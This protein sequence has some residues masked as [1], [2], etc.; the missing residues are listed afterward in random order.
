MLTAAQTFDDKRGKIV[1]LVA[2]LTDERGSKM[3]AYRALGSMLGTSSAWVRRI[4]GRRDDVRIDHH[5]A[6]RIRDLHDRLCVRVAR[7]ADA[8]EARNA[9]I[10]EQIDAAVQASSAAGVRLD[11]AAEADVAPPRRPAPAPQ[12]ALAFASPRTRGPAQASLELNDLP[13]WQHP[14]APR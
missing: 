12:P 9:L 7:A 11:G 1:D 8:A 4:V 10:Q 14:A 2:K 3:D 6:L 5:V 13:L